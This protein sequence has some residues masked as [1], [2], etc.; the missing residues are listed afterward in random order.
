MTGSSTTTTRP[1][2]ETPCGVATRSSRGPS[3]HV[4]ATSS[5]ARTSG[6]GWPPPPARAAL[7]W[8]GWTVSTL[9]TSPR[10]PGCW[11]SKRP[12][13]VPVLPPR[14]RDLDRLAALDGDRLDA[15][16]SSDTTSAL[17]RRPA[18]STLPASDRQPTHVRANA[19]HGS[20]P[21]LG[22]ERDGLDGFSAHGTR[23]DLGTHA[24]RSRGLGR[25]R[26][27]AGSPSGHCE[28]L[29]RAGDMT[30]RS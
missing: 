1:T 3:G 21:L 8:A 12:G 18:R 19:A 25:Q 10:S 17:D 28:Q 9:S 5:L 30:A 16:A 22:R 4:A 6:V 29:G 20:L 7:V 13:T 11:Q 27:T 15:H 23:D 2:L 14:D 24:G 26:D